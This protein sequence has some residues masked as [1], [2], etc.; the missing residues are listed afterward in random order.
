MSL[1]EALGTKRV[2]SRVISRSFAIQRRI[3]PMPVALM[4][5]P[6]IPFIILGG[7]GLSSKKSEASREI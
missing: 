5:E 2:D 7:I 3:L 1:T 6:P 4:D